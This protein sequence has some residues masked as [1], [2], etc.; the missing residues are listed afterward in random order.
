MH[1]IFSCWRVYLSKHASRQSSCAPIHVIPKK[2]E[3]TCL[4]SLLSYIVHVLRHHFALESAAMS[5]LTRTHSLASLCCFVT[6]PEAHWVSHDAGSN[7]RECMRRIGVVCTLGATHTP[8]CLFHR[9]STPLQTQALLLGPALRIGLTAYTP[10]T[11]TTLENLRDAHCMG[12]RF[13][14]CTTHE[15]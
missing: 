11:C 1:A 4:V 7:M 6:K 12:A 9:T 14:T 2:R 15:G 8:E 10:S 5:M 3:E 13:S